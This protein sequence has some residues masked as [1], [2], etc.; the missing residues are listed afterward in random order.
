MRAHVRPPRC[1]TRH[2]NRGVAPTTAAPSGTASPLRRPWCNRNA[3]SDMR[4]RWQAHG[5]GVFVHMHADV[6][7]HARHATDPRRSAVKIRPPEA[8]SN[9]MS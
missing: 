7:V 5:S 3:A 9:A 1:R 8:G 2:R 4:N 6:D